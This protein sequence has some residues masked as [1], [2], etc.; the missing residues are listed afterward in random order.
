MSSTSTSWTVDTNTDSSVASAP[1]W[2]V[3]TN[4]DSSVASSPTWKIEANTSAYSELSTYSVL[5]D[6]SDDYIAIGSV[7]GMDDTDDPFSI[8]FWIKFNSMDHAKPAWRGAVGTNNPNIGFLFS[9]SGASGSL[10]LVVGKY[11]VGEIKKQYDIDYSTGVWYHFVGT[12]DGSG[13]DATSAAGL[14]VYQNSNKLTADSTSA[15][16]G[17]ITSINS[18]YNWV[19]S[20]EQDSGR[21]NGYMDEFAIWGSVIS[22]GNVNSLYNNGKQADASNIA[23]SSLKCYYKLEEGT[24][25]TATD[26]SGQGNNGTLTN[27]P[28]WVE[29]TPY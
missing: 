4:T 27:D 9:P 18:G 28:I 15:T 8:S 17:T 1:S 23:S 6:G 22:Q 2:T 20:A 12:Y 14:E 19:I 13:G 10:R 7:L 11:G 29:E 16:T 3:D 5:F 21:V 26:S 25:T 24:G